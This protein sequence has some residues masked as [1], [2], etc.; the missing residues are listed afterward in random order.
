MSE[1]FISKWTFI[2]ANAFFSGYPQT[3]L[4][5][6]RIALSVETTNTQLFLI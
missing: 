5:A 6:V 3:L 4:Q 2:L 1:F